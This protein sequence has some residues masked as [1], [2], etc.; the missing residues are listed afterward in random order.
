MY[1]SVYWKVTQFKPEFKIYS[2]EIILLTNNPA[3][4]LLLV[5]KGT[6]RLIQR[7]R[8]MK[9]FELHLHDKSHF[10]FKLVL[11]LSLFC[12]LIFCKDLGVD[13]FVYIITGL[14][15]YNIHQ[16]SNMKLT[17][18]N[19][20]FLIRFSRGSLKIILLHVTPKIDN[21]LSFLINSCEPLRVFHYEKATCFL[22]TITKIQ[23]WRIYFIF[24]NNQSIK[25][26]RVTL[27]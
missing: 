3:P 6:Q 20:I 26:I 17:S 24:V 13:A 2:V 23:T 18:A 21:F 11:H 27:E 9:S 7:K 12:I 14:V 16:S 5:Q 25:P 15:Q 4:Q 8:V 10:I 19:C 1:R 22:S